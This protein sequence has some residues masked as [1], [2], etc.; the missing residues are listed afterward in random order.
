MI[1]IIV[2]TDIE[3][4][5]IYIKNVV[6]ADGVSRVSTTHTS[7]ELILAYVNST[8]LFG[9][10]PAVILENVLS[11][12]DVLFSKNDLILMQQSST[13]LLF[14]E[15]TFTALLKKKYDKYAHVEVLIGK[16]KSVPP[17]STPFA[18]SDAFGRRDK[19]GAWILYCEAIEKGTEPEMLSGM[20]F[21]KIK[22]MIL[23]SQKVYTNTELKNQSS[24]L[25]SLYHEAH[26]GQKDFIIGLEQFILTAL[27][28]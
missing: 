20:L 18:L 1:Y 23:Q 9:N 24:A 19:I 13:K 21:W 3:K 28:Q 16:K 26:N 8:P 6:T 11:Q 27:S 17:T 2:G 5:N 14:L 7:R 10:T 25:V 12:S 22:T 15:D 4:R